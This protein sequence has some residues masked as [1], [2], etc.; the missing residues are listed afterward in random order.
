MEEVVQLLKFGI[1]LGG[2][3]PLEQT[4]QV[5]AH[6]VVHR[7]RVATV[8]TEER[9]H[10]LRQRALNKPGVMPEGGVAAIPNGDIGDALVSR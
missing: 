6:D 8:V 5:H 9:R 3:T 2:Q 1:G 4:S 10:L 7:R